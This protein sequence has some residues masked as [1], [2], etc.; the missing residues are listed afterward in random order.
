MSMT[1]FAT[2]CDVCQE[3]SE[4][5]SKWP[6]CEECGDD[7]CPKHM[8]EGSLDEETNE[9]LCLAC[10]E[11]LSEEAEATRLAMLD[12]AA[13]VEAFGKVVEVIN[14]PEYCS[15]CGDERPCRCDGRW[16]K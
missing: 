14:A 12:G 7:V 5:Y 1:R 11:E 8:E 16:V 9:C 10:A 13:M 15:H 6:S 2:T 3:R 4:E